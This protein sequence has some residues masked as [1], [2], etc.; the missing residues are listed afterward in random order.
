MPE[1][2]R[3]SPVCILSGGLKGA[4]KLLK[5]EA[6]LFQE[7]IRRIGKLI[8]TRPWFMAAE[9][10]PKNIRNLADKPEV[11]RQGRVGKEGSHGR[12]TG[13][14]L[15]GGSSKI[16]CKTI[17][18]AGA[19]VVKD[20][21]D[22]LRGAQSETKT[23]DRSQSKI[24]PI[25]TD[26]LTHGD[27]G[28]AGAG[29]IPLSKDVP[30]M[31]AEALEGEKVIEWEKEKSTVGE[32]VAK[33]WTFETR[34]V[35]NDG[36]NTD[37]SKDGGD[38]FYSLTEE[39]EGGS[40]GCDLSEEDGNASSTAESLSSAVGPTVRPQL[41]QRKRINS[42]IVEGENITDQQTNNMANADT[43]LLHLIY[44]TIRELQME[45]RAESRRA[46]MAT[47]QLQVA[48]CKIAKS[49]AEIEEKLNSV[50]SCTL[51]VEG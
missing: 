42:R 26:F 1:G 16:S 19:G 40:S 2:V 30:S 21:R 4:S 48:V 23:R 38:T 31:V 11:A 50:E 34:K 44:G 6:R 36:K 28:S 37:W 45:T 33:D 41:R 32:D 15:M 7:T 47:K 22:Q 25:K 9:M 27:Q 20:G 51:V 35:E 29:P 3:L 17:S 5:R 49:C 43:K 39:S 24:Q 46:R 8:V 12:L 13:K 18:G 14:R 10:A